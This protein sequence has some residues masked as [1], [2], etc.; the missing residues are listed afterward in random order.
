[1][2][3]T[4]MALQL[5]R[6][7]GMNRSESGQL[8]FS[9]LLFQDLAVI[10]ALALVPLLAGSADEHFDWFKVAMKVLAFAV[11]L[12]G[13]R[14]LLRPVFRF[15]AA[16]GVREVF[17]AATLLLVLSAALFMDALGL[18]MA[19]GTFIAGVLLAE[20]EYRHELENAID[21]FKG[22]LLGLF[23]IS[24]GMSLNLG[25]LYTHLLWVAAS[26]VIL[27]VIKMLTLYLLARLYGIRSSE[28][29]A[30]CQRAE[31]GGR[32]RFCALFYR[33]FS[34]PVSGRS[35]GVIIGDCHIINDDHAATD[36]RD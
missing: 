28:T 7:K 35:D 2:S 32:V 10:P 29:D 5:M 22:L 25:V 15:I 19:L 3:S 36:E 6:E 16:S 14:Y 18:S 17:T 4:A 24:V 34:A 1:M 12:I 33:L 27:V 30:V 8:G 20:S 21:P 13:G 26:V 31:S 9:V 11:M 23:F